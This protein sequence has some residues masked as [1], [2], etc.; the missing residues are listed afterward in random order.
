MKRTLSILFLFF[1]LILGFSQMKGVFIKWFSK[2]GSHF[3]F[4]TPDI[5]K[6]PF[7]RYPQVKDTKGRNIVIPYKAVVKGQKEFIG[8]RIIIEDPKLKEAKIEFKVLGSGK[9]INAELVSNTGNQR[10]YN[11]ELKGVFSYG[12]EE[13]I[14]V[15][16]PSEKQQKTNK[17]DNKQK[18]LKEAKQKI[19]G[20]FR[21]VYLEPKNVNLSLVPLD[22]N[23]E[24]IL[25]TIAENIHNTYSKA[26]INFDIKKQLV[27]D[28]STITT[29]DIDTPD[30]NTLSHYSKMQQS[31]NRL[32]SA[33]NNEY[34]LFITEKASSTGQ[35]G[36]MPLGGQ[37][38]YVYKSK[39]KNTPAHELG[40]GVFRLEHPWSNKLIKTP[41]AAT[42]LLMDYAGGA[43]LSH[44][45]WKQINDPKLKLYTFQKQTEGE[46]RNNDG[47]DLIGN[48]I[49]KV[50]QDTKDQKKIIG[51]LD[52]SKPYLRTG[53]DV[54]DIKDGKIQI[55]DKKTYY[56][57]IENGKVV[58]KTS[59]GNLFPYEIETSTSGRAQI[60]LLTDKCYYSTTYID[61]KKPNYKTTNEIISLIEQKVKNSI[62][63]N[64]SLF[65]P[66]PSCD[67]YNIVDYIKT[68]KQNCNASEVN[69][70]LKLLKPIL[71][72]SNNFDVIIKNINNSCSATLGRLEYDLLIKNIIFILN[73]KHS[74]KANVSEQSEIAILRLISAIS[75]N[76]YFKFFEELKKDNEKLL[77][78]LISEI[79]DHSIF[80]WEGNNHTGF[81]NLLLKMHHK[82]KNP[83]SQEPIKII[84]RSDKFD[85]HYLKIENGKVKGQIQYALPKQ[86]IEQKEEFESEI[87]SEIDLIVIDKE[88]Y[89]LDLKRI[90]AFYVYYLLNKRNADAFNKYLSGYTNIYS[91]FVGLS[92]LAKL[93]DIPKAYR[94]IKATFAGIEIG[95]ST[96]DL[97][98]DYSD[99]CN[100]N[101]E[102][103][104]NLRKLSFALNVATLSADIYTSF[105]I[106]SLAKKTIESANRNNVTLPK[107]ITEKIVNVNDKAVENTLEQLKKLDWKA[108]DINLFNNTFKGTQTLENA[109]SWKLLKDAGRTQL[110]K[111]ADVL[112]TL[113]KARNNP[114]L[115]KLGFTDDILIKIKASTLK[116]GAFKNI[117][118]DLDDFA[119]ALDKNSIQIQNPTAIINKLLD[120]NPNNSQAVHWIMQDITQSVK[121][122]AGKKLTFEFSLKNSSQNTAHIDVITDDLPPL[123]I[124]YKWLTKGTVS[125]EDFI[126]EFVKRDLFNISD[127]SKL[128]WRI[129]GSKLTK[130][131]VLEYLSSP[132]AKIILNSFSEEKKMNLFKNYNKLK[133]ITDKDIN[134][135]I[136][137]YYNQI[138][139]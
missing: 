99:I 66:D 11:L 20:S 36:F 108:D 30:D 37:Y 50:K 81:M 58:Y 100:D 78:K 71:Q 65:I 5:T 107:E 138:F 84:V 95:T 85:A 104:N 41:Q 90:P 86:G 24:D 80:F 38:G 74:L 131:K 109:K 21:L 55:H 112:E 128:Q 8:A 29:K 139:K 16:L 123:L 135:F 42:N 44:F 3:Y 75:Y 118:D 121:E 7:D 103:C 12:E 93:K 47:I 116:E 69:D 114:I 62:W 134:E 51:L 13:I 105:E 101:Q 89:T 48:I 76:D 87:F 102:V 122:F 32:Y 70:E 14:A 53:Y 97:F 120:N 10:E 59:E 64:Q 63:E 54:F 92:N 124:E 31:I 96:T 43:E 34:V 23:S 72:K 127:L 119:T 1:G 45:D 133:G 6:I 22:K 35:K 79:D 91:I 33:K 67:K 9:L 68:H 98:L 40:H 4:D 15:L 60:S 61:W 28:I 129:K 73:Q 88:N 49:I 113:T 39:D 136:K 18:E 57:S 115:K 19:I 56:A 17:E 126:R 130:E 94:T 27:L 77:K 125:K 46:D 111:N 106:Q 132:E 117:L 83:Y 2:E 26:G 82:L 110:M 25:D 137:I 52:S